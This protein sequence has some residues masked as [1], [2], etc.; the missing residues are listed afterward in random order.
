MRQATEFI[1][2]LGNPTGRAPG[3]IPAPGAGFVC[4]NDGPGLAAV[5]ARV[6]G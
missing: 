3:A 2:Q 6:I 5:L 4:V 1:R